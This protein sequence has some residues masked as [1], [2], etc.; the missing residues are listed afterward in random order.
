M[1]RNI[2]ITGGNRGIGLA[3]ARAFSDTGERVAVTYRSGEPP[4]GFL[5]LRC[6]VTDQA[7]IDSAFETVESEYGA[8]EVLVANAGME[9]NAP[10]GDMS[11]RAWDDVLATNLTGAFRVARRAAPS[12]RRGGR[13]I[14]ISSIAGFV[15]SE[16][17]ANYAASKSGLIGMARSLSRELGPRGITVNVIAPGFIETDMTADLLHAE[18]EKFTAMVPLARTASPEEVAAPVVFLASSG[19]S[20]INGAVLLVDGGLA[21]GY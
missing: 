7:S 4:S 11:D 9:S 20:Y 5:A 17:Q 14:F 12:L 10:I 6:D 18:R 19:A 13:I 1:G 3:I 8:V 15:G 2:L 21:M 16:Q